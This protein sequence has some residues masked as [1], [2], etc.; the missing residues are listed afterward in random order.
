MVKDKN[1]ILT[2]IEKRVAVCRACPLWRYPKP[3]AGE[4]SADARVFFIGEAPGY[5]ESVQG[6]PFVG[7]AGKLLD[8]LLESIN[9][10]RNQVFIGNMLKHRP[11]NNRDPEQSEMAACSGFLDEQLKTVKP[12]VIVTLGR[13]SLN[14]FLPDIYISQ[15]HGQVRKFNYLGLDFS[16]FPLY[17]PAAGLRNGQLLTALKD[18]FLR[19][20]RFLGTIKT[21]PLKQEGVS[22]DKPPKE[23][24]LS[25][26]N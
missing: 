17:H 10:Q 16:L 15:A 24:Q 19:L 4:G 20:G 7:A 25:L 13:F 18:D 21:P 9:L 11:P 14:K 3:V 5:H 8:Q 23:E 1:S 22:L 26:V 6:R 12:E 2:E